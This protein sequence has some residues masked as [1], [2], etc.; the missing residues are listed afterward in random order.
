MKL[1][2]MKKQK[3]I[4]YLFILP[5]LIGVTI[6]FLFPLLF[7]FVLSFTNWTGPSGQG[8]EFVG[9]QNFQRLVGDSVF[10]QAFGNNFLYLLH[11]PIS[12]I[13]GFIVAVFLNRSV[14]LKNL[15]RAV[16]FLPYLISPIAIGFVWMLLFNPTEGPINVLLMNLGIDNPPGWLASSGS[17]MY[18]IIVMSAWQI[19]GFNIIIYLAALQ[20]VPRELEEAAKMDGAKRWQITKNVIFPFVSP[21]TLFLLIIGIANAFK[22]FGLIQAVT[23]GGPAN[24][25][26]IL[27]LYVYQTA[28]RYYELGYASTIAIVLFIV[29]FAITLLQWFGQKKWVHY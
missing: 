25:T 8:T 9:L 29:I 12:V 23:G 1:N 7:S 15:L 3:L 21:I 18:A 28:F 22:N 13:F 27:P 20:D 6:F 26:N 16:F 2:W 17:S 24:S 14:Y 10:H 19:M 11:V 4:G 5:S